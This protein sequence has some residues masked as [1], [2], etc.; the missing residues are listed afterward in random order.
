MAPDTG[1]QGAGVAPGGWPQAGPGTDREYAS[2]S[3][4]SAQKSFRSLRK[5]R[6]GITD[7]AIYYHFESKRGLFEALLD[8]RGFTTA[9]E[10]LEKTE[11]A[12]IR[13][14]PR[15]ALVGLATG[16]LASRL[17]AKPAATARASGVPG[18]ATNSGLVATN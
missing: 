13:I 4:I 14:S 3:P 2:N 8:E 9:L 16:A 11:L 1:L 6:A 7:A 18:L 10:G 12:E 5:P 17:A 15:E